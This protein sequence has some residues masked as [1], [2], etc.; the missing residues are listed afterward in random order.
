MWKK[1]FVV[2]VIVLTICIG[3]TKI[4]NGAEGTEKSLS[5]FID[6]FTLTSSLRSL[7]IRW[8]YRN[9]TSD[10]LAP[11]RSTG[12]NPRI[13]IKLNSI[14]REIRIPTRPISRTP[15]RPCISN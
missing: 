8:N 15:Y 14:K 1:K 2:L 9:N 4:T 12:V 5:N 7:S 11:K 6:P 13:A 3:G 10:L